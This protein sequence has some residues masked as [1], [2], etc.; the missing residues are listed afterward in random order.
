ML[1]RSKQLILF[2]YILVEY[3][4]TGYGLINLI[5]KVILFSGRHSSVSFSCCGYHC[6]IDKHSSS[7]ILLTNCIVLVA[8][9]FWIYG[10]SEGVKTVFQGFSFGSLMCTVRGLHLYTCYR[11]FVEV[12]LLCIER[13]SSY[14][15]I[16]FHFHAIL[17]VKIVTWLPYEKW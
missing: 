5:L 1:Q 11:C 6:L 13:R 4:V 15:R 7:H 17:V 10:Y 2:S 8:L 3:F 16:Y 9:H 12:I 14:P